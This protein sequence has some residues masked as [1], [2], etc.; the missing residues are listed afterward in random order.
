MRS[1]ETSAPLA[2]APVLD[3]LRA[4]EPPQYC[5][6]CTLPASGC[7]RDARGEWTWNCGGGCNP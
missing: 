7:V 1:L 2:M 3:V 4:P 6:C 5:P